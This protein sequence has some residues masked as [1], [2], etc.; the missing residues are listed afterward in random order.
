M[1]KHIR[2]GILEFEELG[3]LTLDHK[4]LEEL[5]EKTVVTELLRHAPSASGLLD[6][7]GHDAGFVD[8]ELAHDELLVINTDRSGENLA[9]KLGLSGPEVVG[10]FAVTHAV[11]DVVAS[12]G[13][14][15][16][17]T[18]ALLLPGDKSLQYA[19]KV[20]DGV[21]NAAKR[22]ELII[23]SGDTKKNPTVALVVTVTGKA[24]REC[25]LTRSGAKPGDLIAVTGNLGT[26][27]TAAM[28]YKKE[29]QI[30][31]ELKGLLV[32][33]L[34]HQSPPFKFANALNI[35]TKAR[36]CTDISDGLPGAIYDLC[37]KSEVG[38]TIKLQD[39]PTD[40]VVEKFASEKLKIARDSLLASNGDW[41]YLY[42]IPESAYPYAYEIALHHNTKISVIGRFNNR[43][44]VTAYASNGCE[45][46]L[47]HI[48]NNGF[49]R[50]NGQNYFDYLEG[51]PSILGSLV[52][53]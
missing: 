20:M 5:G 16:L 15:L 8:I 44:K 34:T 19:K 18:V 23:A 27:F 47:E 26:M 53:D 51:N 29:V 43:S 32:R 9:Y 21:G 50:I 35:S 33:A 11:S 25:R 41:Q 30:P 46:E 49:T 36:A 37:E 28:S 3:I 17:M 24:R 14:P 42:A 22:F 6:G 40:P 48:R 13:T 7:L 1:L 52:E 45:Y 10:D 4:T 12:G 31:S 2:R 39:V 38:A